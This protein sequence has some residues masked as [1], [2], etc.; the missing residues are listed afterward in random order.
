MLAVSLSKAGGPTVACSVAA[1]NTPAA[2]T[3]DAVY[4]APAFG[5]PAQ[6]RFQNACRLGFGDQISV[7]VVC[8]G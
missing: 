8:A 6:L 3:A 1:D 5:Q 4:L 2:A 7:R